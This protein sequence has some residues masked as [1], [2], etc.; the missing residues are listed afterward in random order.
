[1]PSFSGSAENREEAL[2][3]SLIFL[4]W[5]PSLNPSGG[6]FGFLINIFE[7]RHS[8]SLRSQE[9]WIF[10]IWEP[11]IRHPSTSENQTDTPENHSS[12]KPENRPTG[13]MRLMDGFLLTF[14][15]DERTNR[16]TLL[17]D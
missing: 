2:D 9:C 16:L 3:C 7:Q 14:L 6:H 4:G 8:K 13:W 12:L 5:I 15:R 10:V 1:M 11:E 17:C